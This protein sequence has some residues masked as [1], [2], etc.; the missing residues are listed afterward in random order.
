MRGGAGDDILNGGEGNDDLQGDA[1]DD[2][3]L[4]GNGNDLLRADAGADILN[5][6]GGYDRASYRDAGEGLTIDMLNASLSTGIA[7]GDTFVSIEV[8]EG[9]NFND[10]IY[11]TDTRNVLRGFDGDDDIYGRGGNDLL[12]GF[13]GDDSIMGGAGNDTV[14]GG[15]GTDLA[16]FAGDLADY[17]FTLLGNGN[18]SVVDNVGN[19][20]TD[21]L[22]D[23][24]F[25][26]F[27]GGAEI[28]ITGLI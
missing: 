19:E 1:G 24:E 22:I 16:M 15:D 23:I 13:E 8:I 9:T 10:M 20:G 11:G 28:D 12:Q 26:S 25:V 3:L 18:V 4:A 2:I 21:I 7:R 5:G 27:N 14:D 6:G 17:T